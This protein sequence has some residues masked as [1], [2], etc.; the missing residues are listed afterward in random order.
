MNGI[1]VKQCR[2]CR[3]KSVRYL[4]VTC[5]RYAKPGSFVRTTGEFMCP[6]AFHLAK[7]KVV[8]QKIRVGQ[9]KQEKRL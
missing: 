9:Q 5:D 4:C 6:S 3:T 2:N 7:S 8:K 1:I